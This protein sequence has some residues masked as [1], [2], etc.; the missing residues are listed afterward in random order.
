MRMSASGGDAKDNRARSAS[1]ENA[2]RD[3]STARSQAPP[4][5]E[6]ASS[7]NA[8]SPT[9][10]EGA[11]SV[12]GGRGSSRTS[13]GPA[14]R[15][16]KASIPHGRNSGSSIVGRGSATRA[17]EQLAIN[18]AQGAAFEDATEAS[19]RQ[20]K[21]IIGRQIMLKTQSGIRTRVDFLTLD[22]AGVVT[23]IECKAS[24]TAPLTRNHAPA[25]AEIAKTGATIVGAGKPGFPGGTKIPPTIVRIIR[26]R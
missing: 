8:P 21:V 9:A 24:Q 3:R 11:V 18:R 25:H 1:G 10:P 20:D 4:P 6:P 13:P 5:E 23:C 7:G 2:P 16:V 14:T 17:T 26:G 22:A 15:A 19:L 12:S